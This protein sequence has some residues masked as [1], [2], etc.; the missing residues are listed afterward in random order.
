MVPA[1][2]SA[3]VYHFRN[4]DGIFVGRG[5]STGAVGARQGDI[6]GR[7]RGLAETSLVGSGQGSQ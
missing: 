6:R 2:I 3:L 5:F 4:F 1:L 7:P